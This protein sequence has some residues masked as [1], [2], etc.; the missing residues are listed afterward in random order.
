MGPQAPDVIDVGLGFTVAWDK[1][2]GFIGR[3]ALVTQRDEL[4]E[5]D[6]LPGRRAAR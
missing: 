2:G 3:E 6:G 5:G 1:A 4:G